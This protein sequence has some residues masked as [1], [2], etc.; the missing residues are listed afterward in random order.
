MP[1][2]VRLARVD[3]GLG[4]WGL[5]FRGLGPMGFRGLGF[6]GSGEGFWG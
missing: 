3:L 1:S 5:R 6:R 4:V 2:L